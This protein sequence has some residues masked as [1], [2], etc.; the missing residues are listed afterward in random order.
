M[1][2]ESHF[3]VCF[4]AVGVAVHVCDVQLPGEEAGP[5]GDDA[6]GWVHCGLLWACARCVVT[7]SPNPSVTGGAV[8]A[9]NSNSVSLAPPP[10]RRTHIL[11]H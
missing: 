8:W 2:I 6:A 3:F 5:D 10:G 1:N 4:F 9:C 7:R 11:S